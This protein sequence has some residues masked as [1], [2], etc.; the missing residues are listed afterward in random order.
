MSWSLSFGL[1][2]NSKIGL[3]KECGCVCYLAQDL[4]IDAKSAA[5]SNV[6]LPR[7][8]VVAV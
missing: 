8:C 2:E 1:V 6:I 4:R 5:L 7:L 3:L